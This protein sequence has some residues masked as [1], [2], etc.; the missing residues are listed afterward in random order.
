MVLLERPTHVF[1]VWRHAPLGRAHSR[2][3]FLFFAR[4]LGWRNKWH[5]YLFKGDAILRP[6]EI[7][8]LRI[9]WAG[10]GFPWAKG[11]TV[12]ADAPRLWET[13]TEESRVPGLAGSLPGE[14]LAFGA[15]RKGTWVSA[16]LGLPGGPFPARFEL[17]VL[18]EGR[19]ETTR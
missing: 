18:V 15:A 14:A 7:L 16:F 4:F 19:W 12:H 10:L 2:V 1:C 9:P 6:R 13:S 11:D 8:R 17:L 3:F 5:L